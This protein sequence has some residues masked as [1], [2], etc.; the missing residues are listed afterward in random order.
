MKNL[1][2]N[3]VVVVNGSESS[4]AAA[5]YA[6][7]LEKAYGCKAT[8][9]YVVDT[10][11]I[12]LLELARIFVDEEST[13]YERSLMATGKRYLSFVKELAKDKKLEIEVRLLKGSI[14]DEAVKAADEV[15]AD[16]ILI[17]G[18]EK[19]G[20][21]RDINVEANREI[22]KL[23]HCSVLVVKGA[24]AEAAYRAI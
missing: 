17:G 11:T 6:I 12:R 14:A 4:I 1:L 13:E 18:W 15:G 8:A 2:S 23:A 3:I 21:F 7:A 24:A 20:S 22:T 10:A 9:I 5:K 16:C 19:D